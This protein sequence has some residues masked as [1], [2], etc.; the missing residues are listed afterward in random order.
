MLERLPVAP[1]LEGLLG[2]PPGD[3]E[4]A[5]VAGDRAQEHELLEAGF[6]VDHAGAGGE[7][8]FEL[9]TLP[10]RHFDGVDLHDGHAPTL[11]T[12]ARSVCPVAVS[13]R[14]RADRS[15]PTGRRRYQ[16]RS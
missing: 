8:S 2:L 11:R 5:V 12:A 4:V 10:G 15:G 9:V 16:S 14:F 3:D 13:A 7:P 1:R 6:L